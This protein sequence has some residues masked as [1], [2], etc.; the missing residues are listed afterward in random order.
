MI[1]YLIDTT[2]SK[3]DV[4]GNCYNYSVVTSTKTGA[5]LRINSGYGS[6]GGNIK[7]MLRKAGLDWSEIHYSE[8]LLPIREFWR[9]RE[10]ALTDSTHEHEVTDEMILGL[11][12]EAVAP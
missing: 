4:S 1:R 5:T 11:E 7:A 10:E 3:R 8:R 12:K 9:R 2:V 6:D